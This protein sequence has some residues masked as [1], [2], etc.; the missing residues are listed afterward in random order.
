MR[1]SRSSCTRR[2]EEVLADI[3]EREA[4]DEGR[5]AAPLRRAPDAVE[6]DTTGNTL[7]QSKKLLIETVKERMGACGIESHE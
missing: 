3:R 4:R 5:A 1:R 7:E 2:Y 6:L